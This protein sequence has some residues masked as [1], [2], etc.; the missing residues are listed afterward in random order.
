LVSIF[1]KYSLFSQA[2]VEGRHPQSVFAAKSVPL[3]LTVY[4]GGEIVNFL[5][6]LSVRTHCRGPGLPG[7]V[8]RTNIV[9]LRE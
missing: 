8:A 1:H 4:K 7:S 9:C 6:G 2:D 3:K 5:I